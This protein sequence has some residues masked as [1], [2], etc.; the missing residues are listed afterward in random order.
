MC[1]NSNGQMANAMIKRTPWNWTHSAFLCVA[2]LLVFSKSSA[3]TELLYPP[4]RNALV[5]K[6]GNTLLNLDFLS[7]LKD[8]TGLKPQNR[9]LCA[10][11][12]DMVYNVYQSNG[13]GDDVKAEIRQANQTL[14]K[15]GE[16]FCTLFPA[17]VTQALEKQPFLEAN[18]FNLTAKFGEKTYCWINCLITSDLTQQTEIR[19]ICK[20]ISG[21]CKW[22]I[23]QRK[24]IG[25]MV[26]P[27][28]QPAEPKIPDNESTKLEE[29][30]P[31]SGSNV[32]SVLNA[33]PQPN[34]QNA[35]NA[36]K[37]DT[38]PDTKVDGT[39][40]ELKKPNAN[41]DTNANANVN[42][43]LDSI[44][45]P[46]LNSDSGSNSKPNSNQSPSQNPNPSPSMNPNPS[47]NPN[48]LPDLN[49]HT[50][51]N[52]SDS[53]PIN[54]QI[55]SEPAQKDEKKVID[56]PAVKSNENRPSTVSGNKPNQNKD[57]FT[58]QREENINDI[59]NIQNGNN[60]DDQYKNEEDPDKQ[61]DDTEPGNA[62]GF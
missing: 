23:K 45:P 55:P 27:D 61:E 60:A 13:K 49:Q 26:G 3:G 24:N 35:I 44:R 4:E 38:I 48:P 12:Y 46:Q 11:Y 25:S 20:S 19:E 56:L 18:N 21:G 6:D 47:A 15:L 58:E 10:T 1:L 2:I 32:V 5:A 14:E 54:M 30:L 53:K 36:L 34:D 17:E 52:P 42:K 40:N 57:T 59:N 41:A 16:Q 50:N 28:V 37:P 51:S 62:R 8:C 33:N 9:M 31:V 22:I 39:T 7:F 43:I 29:K